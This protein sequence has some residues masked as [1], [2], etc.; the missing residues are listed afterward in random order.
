MNL[1]KNQTNAAQYLV[2]HLTDLEQTITNHHTSTYSKKYLI[3]REGILSFGTDNFDDV[4]K[5]LQ[6]RE[7]R[8]TFKP[9]QATKAN[10]RDN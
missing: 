6:N 9:N 4:K 8:Y 7:V 5:L 10:F 3:Y 1:S 2:D